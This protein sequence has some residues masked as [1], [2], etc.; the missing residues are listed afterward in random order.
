MTTIITAEQ[1]RNLLDYDSENGGFTWRMRPVVNTY[2]SRFNNRYAGEKAGSLNKKGYVVIDIAGCKQL[3]HRI[4]WLHQ[5]GSMPTL[6][7]DHIN[8]NKS[9]NRIENLREATQAQNNCNTS[10]RNRFGKGVNKQGNKYSG[11]IRH[12]GKYFYLG[13]FSTPEEAHAAY[14]AAAT[15]LHGDFARFA[16]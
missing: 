7:I 11:Q 12:E 1:V 9:D 16:A 2:S 8:G 5:T 6:H 3:L 4:V 15:R 10:K 13:L 14:C